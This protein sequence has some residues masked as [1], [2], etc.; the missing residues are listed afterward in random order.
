MD[1]TKMRKIGAI[2][3]VTLSFLIFAAFSIRLILLKL[4]IPP[5]S[6]QTEGKYVAY[7]LRVLSFLMSI[8]VLV[9]L[10]LF[11]YLTHPSKFERFS[12][13]TKVLSIILAVGGFGITVIL[14]TRAPDIFI[15]K[16]IAG[17]STF[18]IMGIMAVFAYNKDRLENM[19]K[20][21]KLTIF[22]IMTVVIILQL[23]SVLFALLYI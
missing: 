13:T 11:A 5:W 19:K 23:W 21:Y 8:P 12:M 9:S 18:W 20:E 1:K 17:T 7:S 10:F 4:S 2:L 15:I 3:M 22:T 6:V 14:I 16:K